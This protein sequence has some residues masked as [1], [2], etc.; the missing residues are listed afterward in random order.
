MII[1]GN[2]HVF[3]WSEGLT[4]KVY[5]ALLNIIYQKTAFS[6]FIQFLTL[7]CTQ[8]TITEYWTTLRPFIVCLNVCLWSQKHVFAVSCLYASSGVDDT[9]SLP[10]VI[11]RFCLGVVSGVV[12]TEFGW[13]TSK[14]VQKP[15][16]VIKKIM[17]AYNK[18][19]LSVFLPRDL[20]IQ[21]II[22]TSIL[23][24][25]SHLNLFHKIS[26]AVMYLFPIIYI[27]IGIKLMTK[28]NTVGPHNSGRN[29]QVLNI[30]ICVG[31]FF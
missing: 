11:S 17:F 6:M 31:V 19:T 12:R 4:S 5:S 1:S 25:S 13:R 24:R 20:S 16:Q 28:L 14:N 30:I 18:T 9:S 26:F 15:I 27:F 22:F 2:K 10:S 8:A 7:Y 3:N 21:L 23:R 29:C